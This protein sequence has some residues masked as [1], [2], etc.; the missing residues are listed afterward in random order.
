[1]CLRLL[2]LLPSCPLKAYLSWTP[3]H[4]LP[5]TRPAQG[6]GLLMSRGGPDSPAA[7]LPL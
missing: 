3:T 4:G 2:M 6:T 5:P 7:F 1:M